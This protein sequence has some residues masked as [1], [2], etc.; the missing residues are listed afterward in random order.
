VLI[1]GNGTAPAGIHP[2]FFGGVLGGEIPF[3]D[4]ID[5]V[6]PAAGFLAFGFLGSRLPRFCPLAILA[7]CSVAQRCALQAN[8]IIVYELSHWASRATHECA[9]L[10][11]PAVHT[12]AVR[13]DPYANQRCL[14]MPA[15]RHRREIGQG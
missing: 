6:G 12:P 1:G 14:G 13:N 10:G 4:K 11:R 9:R 5:K 8:Q 15:N 7:S 2:F 3:G